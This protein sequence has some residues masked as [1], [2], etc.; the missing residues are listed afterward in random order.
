MKKENDIAKRV[1]DYYNMPSADKYKISYRDFDN[2]IEILGL[3]DDPSCNV[4]EYESEHIPVP[5]MW[6]T[7]GTFS[8]NKTLPKELIF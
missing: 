3:V 8:A 5:K 7:L 6:L 4:T 1:A 2:V